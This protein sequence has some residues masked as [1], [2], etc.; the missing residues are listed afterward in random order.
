LRHWIGW[1]VKKAGS[2]GY[3]KSFELVPKTV[4]RDT[5]G[6]IFNPKNVSG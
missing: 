6:V 2:L 4:S 3:R 5:K 1:G